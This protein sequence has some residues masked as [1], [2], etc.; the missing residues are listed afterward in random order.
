MNHADSFSL[1]KEHRFK[2]SLRHKGGVPSQPFPLLEP[3]GWGL[4]AGSIPTAVPWPSSHPG[5]PPDSHRAARPVPVDF[6][7]EGKGA[8]RAALTCFPS[9]FPIPKQ[10]GLQRSQVPLVPPCPEPQA[11]AD[12]RILRSHWATWSPLSSCD[13]PGN[14]T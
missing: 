9:P 12:P 6:H 1:P 8:P 10:T 13:L 5:I 14:L 2:R 11:K 7:K 4:G 3:Q